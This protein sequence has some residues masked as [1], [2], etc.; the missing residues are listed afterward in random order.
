M[1]SAKNLGTVEELLREASFFRIHK[2]HLINIDHVR[3]Y[4]KND[5]PYVVMSN[6]MHLTIA[7][8]RKEGFQARF[9]RL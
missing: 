4:V 7:R 5:G 6:G 1:L 8:N 3:K 2:H 9:L